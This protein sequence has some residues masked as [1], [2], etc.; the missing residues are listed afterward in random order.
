MYFRVVISEYDGY[1][2]E[3]IAIGVEEG[4]L[5]KYLLLVLIIVGAVLPTYYYIKVRGWKKRL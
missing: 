1:D 5:M 4:R 3:M 2:S